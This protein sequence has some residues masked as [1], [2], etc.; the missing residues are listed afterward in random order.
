MYCGRGN[1]NALKKECDRSGVDR[2]V[3]IRYYSMKERTTRIRDF[4]VVKREFLKMG[5]AVNWIGCK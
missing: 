4:K 3:D 1:G 5:G 2:Q